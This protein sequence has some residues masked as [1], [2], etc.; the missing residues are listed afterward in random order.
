MEQSE[1]ETSK[2][3]PVSFFFLLFSIAEG[4]SPN[5]ARIEKGRH[6]LTP[7]ALKETS[8]RKRKEIVAAALV[9]KIIFRD[10][11]TSEISL[12]SLSY[13]LFLCFSRNYLY[14]PRFT[15]RI[16]F[17]F[18]DPFY[19]TT[20]SKLSYAWKIHEGRTLMLLTATL[21]S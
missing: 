9:I 3:F 10:L 4:I 11:A 13:F 12:S 20:H 6:S 5:P 16:Q 1:G 21:D 17:S 7:H 8:N 18:T 19:F 15:G 14:F 2:N